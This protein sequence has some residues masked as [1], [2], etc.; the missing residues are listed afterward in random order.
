MRILGR[1]KDYYD[2]GLALGIDSDIVWVRNPRN[3]C[4]SEINS[5]TSKKQHHPKLPKFKE[6]VFNL[7]EIQYLF[8]RQFIYFCG[9][10]IHALEVIVT[11]SRNYKTLDRKCFYNFENFEKYIHKTC[12]KPGFKRLGERN[13]S[14]INI[15]LSYGEVE[16]KDNIFIE[17]NTPIFEVF[18]RRY[19]H[20]EYH[21]DM[22]LAD[23]TFIRYMDPYQCFQ[24]ISMYCSNVL[25]MNRK[26]SSKYK[27][28][29]LMGEISDLDMRD[30]KGF[31]KYSFRKDKDKNE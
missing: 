26:T 21:V 6:H 3:I 15:L 17:L 25:M 5:K 10:R 8:S 16:L 27:G 4:S 23:Y 28:Q 1:S 22:K 24:Q 19:G 20:S 31:N 14:N 18:Y 29:E 2:C 30:A 13:L 9:R 11:D 7:S 12:G